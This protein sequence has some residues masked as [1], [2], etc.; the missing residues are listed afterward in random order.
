MLQLSFAFFLSFSLALYLSLSHH[1]LFPFLRLTYHYYLCLYLSLLHIWH[2]PR[3]IAML[4]PYCTQYVYV[5]LVESEYL[6]RKNTPWI[7]SSVFTFWLVLMFVSISLFRFH[8]LFCFLYSWKMCL[9]PEICCLIV[10]TQRV[11]QMT[12]R[13]EPFWSFHAHSTSLQSW[14]NS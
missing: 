8:P 2:S 9:W 4:L 7:F 10:C 5:S 14:W 13:N 12:Y 6:L 3:D 1:P 11:S